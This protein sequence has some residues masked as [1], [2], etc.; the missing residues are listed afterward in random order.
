MSKLAKILALTNGDTTNGTEPK[1]QRIELAKYVASAARWEIGRTGEGANALL[2]ALSFVGTVAG[3]AFAVIAKQGH[4][5]IAAAVL[6]AAAVLLLTA[7]L[8]IVFALRPR[9][10]RRG[11]TGSGW[12]ALLQHGDDDDAVLTHLTDVAADLPGF[13]ATDARVLAGIAHAK[14]RLIRNATTFVLCGVPLGVLGGVL[15]GIGI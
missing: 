15:Y 10:P 13:Y 2:T 5:L 7:F 9:L 4:H 6:A 12:T 11:T 3:A 1:D 8:C 14:H